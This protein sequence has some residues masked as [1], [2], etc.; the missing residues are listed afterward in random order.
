MTKEEFESAKRAVR[1]RERGTRV[2]DLIYDGQRWKF[3]AS[4]GYWAQVTLAAP[5]PQMYRNSATMCR[6]RNDR[7][8]AMGY[9]DTYSMRERGWP[10]DPAYRRNRKTNETDSKNNP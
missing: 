4:Q 6:N 3:I 8:K 10:T 5:E 2:R 7:R 9:T 1:Y